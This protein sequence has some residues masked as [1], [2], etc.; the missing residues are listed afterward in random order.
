MAKFAINLD[1]GVICFRNQYIDMQVNVKPI[2]QEVVDMI[3][4]GE[5]TTKE[6]VNAIG[7][8]LRDDPDFDFSEYIEL[9]KRLNVRKS[10]YKIQDTATP[11]KDRSDEEVSVEEIKAE[12]AKST[13]KAEKKARVKKVQAALETA[14][15]SVDPL[16]G[17]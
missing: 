16:A 14:P 17:L 12:K 5:V 7:A 1:T 11:L 2:P 9:K 3:T 8:K 4:S 15:A 13:N 10:A 6:V